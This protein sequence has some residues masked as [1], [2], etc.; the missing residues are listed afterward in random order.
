MKSLLKLFL[1]F[2]CHLR[3]LTSTCQP[4]MNPDHFKRELN[5]FRALSFGSFGQAQTMKG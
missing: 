5:F 1:N 4:E 3:D 2:E